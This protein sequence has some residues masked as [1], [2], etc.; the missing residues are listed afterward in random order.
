MIDLEK[1][2]AISSMRIF[3]RGDGWFDDGLPLVVEVSMNGIQFTEVARRTTHYDKWSCR[4]ARGNR[5]TLGPRLEGHARRARAERN[6]SLR[7]RVK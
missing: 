6:R 1:P 5:G 3:N 4:R 2:Y 7:A